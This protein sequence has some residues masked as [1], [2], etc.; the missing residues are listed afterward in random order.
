MGQLMRLL[1]GLLF[2]LIVATLA[3]AQRQGDAVKP[4]PSWCGGSYSITGGLEPNDYVEAVKTGVPPST[5]TNFESC[6]DNAYSAMP[7]SQ[8]TLSPDGR[9]V[10]QNGDVDND[11]KAIVVELALRRC[12]VGAKTLR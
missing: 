12:R 6:D 3:W 2:A 10:D 4:I 8:V 5:G 11:G 1:A 9:V 7:S